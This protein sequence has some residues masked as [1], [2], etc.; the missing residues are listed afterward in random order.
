MR[1]AGWVSG[2]GALISSSEVSMGEVYFYRAAG[3][4]VTAHGSHG[5]TCHHHF[6]PGAPVFI[7]WRPDVQEAGDDLHI[8]R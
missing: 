1:G 2:M 4:R 5:S 7:L 3:G 6:S 8:F